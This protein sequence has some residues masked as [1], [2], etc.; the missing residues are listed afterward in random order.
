MRI[1]T[2][3]TFFPY[4][5]RSI[6][7]ISECSVNV[8][9][10]GFA[11]GRA[12]DKHYVP[13]RSHL[14]IQQAGGLAQQTPGPIAHHRVSYLFTCHQSDTRYPLI[15][16]IYCQYKERVSPHMT[17]RFHPLKVCLIMQPRTARKARQGPMARPGN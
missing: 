6:R 10:F 17:K 14:V 12:R 15:V 8:L 9:R 1:L 5:P 2:C 11:D 3:S 13:P 4:Q 16:L 7:Y